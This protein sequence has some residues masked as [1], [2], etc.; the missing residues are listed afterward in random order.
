MAHTIKKIKMNCCIEGNNLK[1]GVSCM[2][3]GERFKYLFGD[4]YSKSF[5]KEIDD[6]TFFTIRFWYE[7]DKKEEMSVVAD[8]YWNIEDADMS[9]QE[10]YSDEFEKIKYYSYNTSSGIAMTLCGID[11]QEEEED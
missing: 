4:Y 9:N 8:M 1:K 3:D 11:F 7:K 10:K 5:I 6:E 2:V